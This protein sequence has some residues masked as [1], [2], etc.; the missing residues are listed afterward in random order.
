MLGGGGLGGELEGANGRKMSVLLYGMIGKR[1]SW[2]A[3]ET[4]LKR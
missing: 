3:L 2:I 1:S 4:G